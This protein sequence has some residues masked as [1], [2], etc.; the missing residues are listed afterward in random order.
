[1][2]NDSDRQHSADL[3]RGRSALCNQRRWYKLQGITKIIYIVTQNLIGL[4]K[5]TSFF[6]FDLKKKNFTSDKKNSVDIEKL[7]QRRIIV[8]ICFDKNKS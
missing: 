1:M 7:F 2:G 5:I 6:T 4:G 3:R 8:F